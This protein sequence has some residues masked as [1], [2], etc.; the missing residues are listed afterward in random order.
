[1]ADIMRRFGRTIGTIAGVWTLALLGSAGPLGAQQTV[2]LELVLAVDTSGSVDNGE[3]DLQRRGLAAAFRDPTVVAAIRS[4]GRVAVSLV[5]WSGPDEQGVDVAWFTV[6]DGQ[7]A[8]ALANRID[9][10]ERRYYGTTAITALLYDAVAMLRANR[11]EGLRQVI[12]ISGDGPNNS[13][14]DPDRVRDWAVAAGITVNGLAILNEDSTLDRYYR[15]H[16]IGG[17]GAFLIDARDYRAF[18]AAIRAKLIREIRGA[19]VAGILP[20]RSTSTGAGRE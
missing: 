13:G 11:I 8:A 6:S 15:D 2:G 7:S 4:A 5:Q 1:M 19:P 12:D 10:T 16:V 9:A 3:F 17:P 14:Q 18:A 20:N